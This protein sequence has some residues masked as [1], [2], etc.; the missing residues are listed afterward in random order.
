[1]GGGFV[2][3]ADAVTSVSRGAHS[4][5]SEMLHGP[6]SMHDFFSTPWCEIVSAGQIKG[7]LTLRLV[8]PQTQTQT[9]AD[10]D[11]D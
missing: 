5:D 6:N 2:G 7:A 3:T 1:M 4:G 10:T 9:Q 8:D 11:T